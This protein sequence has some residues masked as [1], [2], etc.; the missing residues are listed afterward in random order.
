MIKIK[1]ILEV[2]ENFNFDKV[3]Q[4]ME[5][6]DWTW[7]GSKECPTIEELKERAEDLLI[8]VVSGIEKEEEM[9]PDVAY[10]CGTGGF[11]ATAILGK[12]YK[13]GYVGLK[14]VVSNWDVNKEDYEH[15][16]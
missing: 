9:Q 14:F 6:L 4:T 13:V 8:N 7:R 5:C 2:L 10:H 11:E 1:M 3:K 15:E 16:N 12:D